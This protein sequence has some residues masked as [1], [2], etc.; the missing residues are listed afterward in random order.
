MSVCL[1][2]CLSVYRSLSIQFHPHAQRALTRPQTNKPSIVLINNKSEDTLQNKIYKKGKNKRKLNKNKLPDTLTDW[3]T[4]WFID[5]VNLSTN[6]LIDW[7]EKP[8]N[9][10]EKRKYVH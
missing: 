3:L 9:I 2:V 10:T 7:L 4:D 5:R 6:Q 1:S 8:T